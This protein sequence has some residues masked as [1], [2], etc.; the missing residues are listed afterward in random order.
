VIDRPAVRALCAALAASLASP[1]TEAAPNHWRRHHR[2]IHVYDPLLYPVIPPV[3]APAVPQVM[4]QTFGPYALPEPP[5]NGPYP[6]TEPLP[7]P[8]GM[9]LEIDPP[10]GRT[11]APAR[12][13]RWHD[14]GLALRV[15]WAAP[16]RAGS[17]A[18]EPREVTLR[19]G[20][21]RSGRVLGAPRVTY[22]RPPARSDVQR[23]FT[24]AALAAL[25]RCSPL[26]FTPG[27]GSAIA[28]V[29]FSIRFTDAQPSS[30]IK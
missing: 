8:Q 20:F 17:A 29:P 16:A 7:L 30:T 5:P 11:R 6:P 19:L 28:G 10:S 3:V 13:D 25:A 4:P 1:A 22:A 14:V 21:S 9:K 27:L 2:R 12:L 15:C 24:A 18:I 26:R 23:A